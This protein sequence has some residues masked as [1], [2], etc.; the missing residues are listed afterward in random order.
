MVDI[1]DQL[2]FIRSH[3]VRDEKTYSQQSLMCNT[4]RDI[5]FDSINVNYVMGNTLDP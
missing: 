5:G 2:K 3:M 1:K 4:T